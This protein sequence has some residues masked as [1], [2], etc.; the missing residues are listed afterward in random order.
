[1]ISLEDALSLL[2]AVLSKVEV[3]KGSGLNFLHCSL[4]TY[5]SRRVLR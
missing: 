5:I 1:M 2:V 3:V 4:T